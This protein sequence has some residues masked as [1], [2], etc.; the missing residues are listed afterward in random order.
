[1]GAYVASTAKTEKN[2]IKL[3]ELP[4]LSV[5]LSVYQK[6]PVGDQNVLARLLKLPD[7]F[8]SAKLK[9]K[10]DPVT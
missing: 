2:A 8:G 6:L 10:E 4:P 7:S 9:A 5:T 1:M 3:P